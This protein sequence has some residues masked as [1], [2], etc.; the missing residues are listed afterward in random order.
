[1]GS[2]G[3][4]ESTRCFGLEGVSTWMALNGAASRASVI[5]PRQLH[6]TARIKGTVR[7]TITTRHPAAVATTNRTRMAVPVASRW[8]Y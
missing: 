6:A 7:S 2:A 1:M 5:P 4:D 3:L 8:Y